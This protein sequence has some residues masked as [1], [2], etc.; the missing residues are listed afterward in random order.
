MASPRVPRFDSFRP[1]SKRASR[2]LAGSRSEG[3]TCERLLRSA[4]WR[5]GLRFRKNF[6]EL[7]GKPDVAFPRQRVAVFCDGDFWHGKEWKR[8]KRKLQKGANAAYW[9]PKIE[10][11]ITRDKAHNAELRRRGWIVLRFWESDILADV[12]RVAEQVAQVVR[13]SM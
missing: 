3:T 10:A 12:N 4:L 11:N 6:K 9:V 2:T 13:A 8:R 1:S 5:M 7:P